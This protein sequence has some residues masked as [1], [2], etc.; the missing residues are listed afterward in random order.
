VLPD[1]VLTY[2]VDVRSR[3][4]VKGAPLSSS[5]IAGL[6]GG[7]RRFLSWALLKGHL[8]QDLPSIIV[9]KPRETLPKP[10]AEG[11]VEALIEKGVRDTRERASSRS[12]TARGYAPPS[13]AASVS[14]TWIS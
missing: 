6:L 2:L 13:C 12:F 14:M 10:L 5:T 4:T 11:E 8:L 3:I 7:V 1:H 9:V